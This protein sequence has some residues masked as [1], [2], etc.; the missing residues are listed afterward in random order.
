MI[1]GLAAAV[2]SVSALPFFS[3]KATAGRFL[4]SLSVLIVHVC[5]CVAYYLYVQSASADAN[6]YYLDKYHMSSA[7]FG[8]GTVFTAQFTQVLKKTFGGGFF[9]CFFF[10]Q[11]IGFW[12]IALLS[13]TF[14]EIQ[15][16]LKAAPAM[17]P[18]YLLFLPSIHFWTSAIGKDA[19]IF[20]A[21]S[22]CMWSALEWR[23]RLLPFGAA[24]VVMILF[25]AHI[26]LISV[27]ALAATA[28]LHPGISFGRKI[29]LFAV[30]VI[31]AYLLL[32]AVQST[33]NVNV[34]DASSVATFLQDRNDKVA[35]IGGGA[36]FGDAPMYYRLL[37]L[38]FRPFFYDA[39]NIPGII[40]SVENIGSVLLF[41]YF[42]SNW[43]ELWFLAK[44]VYFIEYCLVFAGILII[45][46]TMISYNV[47]LGLRERVMVFP[48][49]LSAF[50]A[51]WTMPRKRHQPSLPG[52]PGEYLPYAQPGRGLSEASR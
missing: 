2:I 39:P 28:V 34:T 31:G 21:V 5:A 46:L 49:L 18:N 15:E 52:Y 32:G 25:R 26:A 16:K 12:G 35:Q 27:M 48:P 29:G 44:R 40:A 11:S 7:G 37:T 20:F 45:L 30:T 4:L 36:S 42:L 33:V 38:L 13:R 43:R 47:G 9:E 1:V 41:F 3:R 8:F 51:L 10:F 14:E 22:L 6:A 24:L 17:L 19:P 23:R 50:V